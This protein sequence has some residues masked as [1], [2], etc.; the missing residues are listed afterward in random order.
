[1]LKG[2]HIFIGK[3]LCLSSITGSFSIDKFWINK[4]CYFVFGKWINVR[5]H[6]LHTQAKMG[7]DSDGLEFKCSYRMFKR[8]GFRMFNW[9]DQGKPWRR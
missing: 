9:P 4:N 5:N 6:R 3:S 1:M 2:N 8:I 7:S